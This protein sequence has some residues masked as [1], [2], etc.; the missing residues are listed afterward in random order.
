MSDNKNTNL[1]NRAWQSMRDL[2]D[3]EMPEK[4]KRRGIAWLW[5]STAAGVAAAL[6]IYIMTPTSG[7]V[8]SQAMD[9]YATNAG[10]VSDEVVSTELALNNVEMHDSETNDALQDAAKKTSTA[11]VNFLREKGSIVNKE[12]GEKPKVENQNFNGTSQKNIDR[13]SKSTIHDQFGAD[14]KSPLLA[15]KNEQNKE[16]NKEKMLF[17]ALPNEDLAIEKTSSESDRPYEKVLN[18]NSLESKIVNNNRPSINPEM[19][20]P[21]Y[22]AYSQEIEVQSGFS[23][24]NTTFASLNTKNLWESGLQF[25]YSR[26]V[27]KRLAVGLGASLSYTNLEFKYFDPTANSFTGFGPNNGFSNVTYESN[28]V[29]NKV[30]EDDKESRWN[31]TLFVSLGFQVSNRWNIKA[32]TGVRK[33]F[34]SSQFLQFLNADLDKNADNFPSND[35]NNNLGSADRKSLNFKPHVS[36]SL[37][38][39]YTLFKD[40]ELGAIYMVTGQPLNTGFFISKE[41]G[42]VNHFGG[43]QLSYNF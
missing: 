26:A 21:F 23:L 43:L 9:A 30:S 36:Q 13:V 17:S 29:Q 37:A 12:E 5:F 1:E 18:I 34:E 3:K 15:S 24:S 27:A 38:I 35:P 39:N 25:A 22:P 4:R 19:A 31:S 42:S 8:T 41:I 14:T 33:Y 11:R 10:P 6:I 28:Q 16:I 20:D 2:L 7:L 32:N 40:L